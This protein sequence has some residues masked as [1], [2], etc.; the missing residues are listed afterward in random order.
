MT[1]AQYKHSIK[2]PNQKI[3]IKV[4][5]GD[6]VTWAVTHEKTIVLSPSYISLELYNGVTIGT[7][8]GKS[9][10]RTYSSNSSYKTPFYKKSEVHDIYN[11]LV[12]STQKTFSI[13]FRAYDDGVAYRYI[14][15]INQDLV[16]KD[17]TSDFNFDED[18]K[19]YLPYV[20]DLRGDEEWVQAFEATYDEHKLSEGKKRLAFLPIMV[21]LKDGKKAVITE[22]DQQDYPGMYLVKND[23]NNKGLKAKF[24]PV[25]LETYHGG[26]GEMDLL[27]KKRADYI[28]KT[29]GSRSFPWRTIIISEKDIDLL[30]NDM[31][32]KLAEPSRIVDHSWIKPGKTSWDWWNDWNLSGVNFEAGIN[33]ETYKYYIDFASANKLEYIIIDDGWS[34]RLDL[35]Q[36]NPNLDLPGIIAYAESKSVK[37]I[38]WSSWFAF[39]QDMEKVCKTYSEMGAVGFKVD[40][41]DRD[42]Q[43]VVTSV[44]QMADA[45]AKYHMIL[46]YHG[47]FKPQGIQRTYL[48]I[49][50]LE[51]VKG[52]ENVKWTPYDDVP[53]YDTS[54]PFIRQVVG[55]MDYTPGA[56]RNRN[57][58]NFT[59]SFSMPV[60]QGTRAEPFLTRQFD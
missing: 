12:I 57:K 40:F 50:N 9:E 28:A 3:E 43:E 52:M 13:I 36:I 33:T 6:N 53:R 2:S 30:D 31:V 8:T 14:T 32:Q 34:G 54:I 46:D 48:N 15:E 20:T 45:A 19:I 42:D 55:P 4:C 35:F 27:A 49:L 5:T 22:S 10:E 23:A 51:G 58:A 16:I 26:I 44:Y 17:E 60:S 56:T 47:F 59:P 25:V 7:N 38:L 39:K 24:V 37:V 18:Y 1:Q 11:E 21:E 41:F 29:K